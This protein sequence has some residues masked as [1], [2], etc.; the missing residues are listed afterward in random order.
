MR[1]LIVDDSAVMRR[2]L[3]MAL[4]A[5]RL[6]E[7]VGVARDGREALEMT[8]RLDP[9]VL[10]L[11][12]E[13]PSLNG[14][15]TLKELRALR[16]A[17]RP[18]VLMCS[19]LTASGSET[20]LEAMRLGAADVIAKDTA[21]FGGNAAVFGQELRDKVKAIGQRNAARRGAAPRPDTPARGPAQTR[22]GARPVDVVASLEHIEAV[23]V[24]SSTGGPPVLETMISALPASFPWPVLVAQHMPALFTRSLAD[25]LNRLC[26]A[27]VQLAHHGDRAEPGVVYVAEGGQHLRVQR[28]RG[29][30][31]LEVSPEPASAFYKPSVDELVASAAA[32]LG[33]RALG[34][35]VTGMGE[36]G[37]KGCERLVAAGGRVLSQDEASCVVYGMPRAVAENGLSSATGTPE[38]LAAALVR[39]ATGAA[40]AA[41]SP[42]APA[43]TE[44]A[45]AGGTVPGPRRTGESRAA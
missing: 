25:R 42:P 31:T 5:D 2:A 20:A 40:P 23:V 35:I 21:A 39:L 29:G 15:D 32:T 3:R 22:G 10:T 12:V 19:S 26:Q 45:P 17:R 34:V 38:D 27:K 36:D 1:V 41:A 33:A 37:R 28:G 16:L 11:D 7:V 43:D 4:E 44:G 6:F 18:A 9:D 13:M 8:Q 24:G 30:L 14:L